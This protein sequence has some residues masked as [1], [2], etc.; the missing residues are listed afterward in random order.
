[1]T[2]KDAAKNIVYADWVSKGKAQG[3]F[4]VL[5]EALRE[6][7]REMSPWDPREPHMAHIELGRIKAIEEFLFRLVDPLGARDDKPISKMP[8]PNYGTR[9]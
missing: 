3:F 9:S 4:D 5:A 8:T 6:E 1:M 7:S 2:R